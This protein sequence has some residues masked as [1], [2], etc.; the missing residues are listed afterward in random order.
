MYIEN[1][2]IKD[3]I[4]FFLSPRVCVQVGDMVPHHLWVPQC[5]FPSK[6]MILHNYNTTIKI[7]KLALTHDHRIL[8]PSFHSCLIDCPSN[9]LD[10]KRIQS[11]SCLAFRYQVSLVCSKPEHVP[12]FT[13]TFTT[14]ALEDY[15][16]VLYISH[17][18][19][20]LVF[21]LDQIQV[22]NLRQ[23]SYR[24]DAVFLLHPI[25]S[26]QFQFV[27]FLIVFTVGLPY[28]WVSNTDSTEGGKQLKKKNPKSSKKQ[29]LSL[30]CTGNYLHRFTLCLQL[31]TQYLRCIRRQ[32]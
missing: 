4:V 19:F 1:L 25:M 21:L 8:G 16:L 29:N 18:E 23:D 17:F 7:R 27:L 10:G 5:I 12:I 3:R 26:Y 30:L 14:L 2:H 13:L 31:F 9:V 6:H 32:K 15:S 28:P 24:S 11:E 20:H 22:M